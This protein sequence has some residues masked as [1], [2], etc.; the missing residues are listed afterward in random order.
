MTPSEFFGKFRS[1]F[2]W[3]NLLAMAVLLLVLLF[4][5]KIGLDRYT[6]HGEYIEI[7]DVSKKSMLDARKILVGVGLEI[8]VTDTG[9]VK[10]LPAD[11]VLEQ[12]PM[13]GA[14]V[15]AGHTVS[16]IVNA[17]NTPTLVVPNLVDNCSLREAVARLKAMGFKVGNTRFVHGEKDW[18]YGVLV[19]GR[20]VSAGERVSI[21]KTI[22]VEAGNGMASAEDTLLFVDYDSE[23]GEEMIVLPE[24][25]SEVDEFV[26]IE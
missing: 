9:Y 4:A 15:K 6:H 22:I 10:E 19:D 8:E 13:A 16:L 5:V 2:L 23:S 21:N 11:V 14:K 7:P 12:N 1:W 3:G 18:V 24:E 20:R 17:L 26:E 25:G